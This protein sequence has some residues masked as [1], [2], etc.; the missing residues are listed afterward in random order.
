MASESVRRADAI[1]KYMRQRDVSV[2]VINAAAEL[3]IRAERRMGELL[4]EMPE[5]RG[6][7]KKFQGATSWGAP[8]L[9]HLGVE[10]TLSHRVQMIASVPED[11]FERHIEEVKGAGEELG[12]RGLVAVPEDRE[13]CGRI[14][15]DALVG[16]ARPDRRLCCPQL[17]RR[18]AP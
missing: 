15:R 4:A 13:E 2:E 10:K 14:G 16:C 6:Q 8:T 1:R 3:K 17:T 9:E 11:D 12:G 7:H 5:R 18:R